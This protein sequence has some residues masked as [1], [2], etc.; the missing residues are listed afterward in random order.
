MKAKL[1]AAVASLLA[2]AAPVTAVLAQSYPSRPIK[3]I[4]PY[5]P[6]DGP[7]VIARLIGDK[8][9]QRL[10]QAVVI[11][12][13]AGASGQIGLEL[14]AKAPPDGYTLGVGLVT[15]LA[16]APY[17]YKSIPYDPLKDFTP[18][19]LGAINYLALVARPDAPFKNVGEM[20]QWAK[21]N[22][23]KMTI[24]TTSTGGLPH[25]SF[26]LLAHMSGF[27]FLNVPYKGNGPIV[28]DL[29]GG[30]L[31]LGV[32]SY[33]SI[34]GLA[35]SGRLKVLGITNPARDPAL[36][37]LPTIGETVKGYAAPGWF[38]FVA[39]AGTPH[40]IVAKLNDEINRAIR[41]PEVQKTMGTLG[42]IPQTGSPED[43]G[44]LIK[45]DN[46]KF[47]KLVKDIGY[48]PQ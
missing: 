7:D 47:A 36:P 22:P 18:V 30:R 42:L 40:E 31:D 37:N 13:R 12:N 15:N 16:L 24:G 11:D 8:I 48:Q 46:E 4:V 43:F 2:F 41:L 29:T 25:M 32:T 38:G 23:G 10:G 1:I 35:D 19:A 44:R 45:S 20:I 28:S 17:A 39:P 26:E 21:D 33:T 27:K 3:I 5:T 9:S 6:G 34:A 14:T